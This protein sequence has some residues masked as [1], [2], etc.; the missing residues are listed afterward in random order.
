MTEQELFEEVA[1]LVDYDPNTGSLVWKRREGARK[2]W[3]AKYAGK[4][5]G[6]INN[7]GYRKVCFQTASGKRYLFSAHRLAWYITHSAPPK[8]EIDHID[9]QKANNRIKNLRD[10][11]KSLNMR[12]RKMQGNNT[13]G[14]TGVHWEKR[15]GKWKVQGYLNGKRLSI[16]YF[17]DIHEAEAAVKAF[18][19]KHGFTD[20]HGEAA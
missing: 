12:N 14:V 18:R 9:G 17:S 13:S 4:G 20:T 19:A 6:Y 16:G 2:Q 7:R 11:S 8:G 1:Q 15:S 3:N 10:V 5:C